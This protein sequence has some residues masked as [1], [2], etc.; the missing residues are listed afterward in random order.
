[1][2]SGALCKESEAEC[3]YNDIKTSVKTDFSDILV[4]VG[5]AKCLHWS[6]VHDNAEENNKENC[7]E[8]KLAKSS[9]YLDCLS[10]C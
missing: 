9:V 6:V 5:M 4:H 8:A 3:W 2:S 1:M 7:L 10:S